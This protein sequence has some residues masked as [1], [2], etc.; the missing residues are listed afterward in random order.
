[1]EEIKLKNDV[2][3]LAIAFGATQTVLSTLKDRIREI[4]LDS[5]PYWK[6]AEEISV[7][8]ESLIKSVRSQL[9][10]KMSFSG[11]IDSRGRTLCLDL[12][13]RI[14]ELERLLTQDIRKEMYNEA[15]RLRYQYVARFRPKRFLA[16]KWGF[17]STEKCDE[18]AA[19]LERIRQHLAK[20]L[21]PQIVTTTDDG[22]SQTG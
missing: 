4:R 12:E 18:I 15:D 9:L 10:V 7:E 19:D 20:I 14:K 5:G 17:Q 22:Q 6:C 16:K 1:M 2:V 3:F 21:P 8:M 11:D 13:T